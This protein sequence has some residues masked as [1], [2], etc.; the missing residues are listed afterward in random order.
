MPSACT[1]WC[2][3]WRRR[4]P[5]PKRGTSSADGRRWP[6]SPRSIRPR[7]HEASPGMAGARRLDALALALVGDAEVPRGAGENVSDL[8]NRLART[9]IPHSRTMGGG[10]PYERALAIREKVLWRT[11]TPVSQWDLTTSPHCIKGKDSM[12]RRRRSHRRA[13]VIVE[14]APGPEHLHV[15]MCL[16]NLAELY[17]AQGLYTQARPLFERAMAIVERGARPRGSLM[18]QRS[19][20]TLHFCIRRKGSTLRRSCS[21]KRH[22]P[23]ARKC[24]VPNIPTGGKSQNLARLYRAR[25]PR[26]ASGAVR[27]EGDGHPRESAGAEH[28]DVARDLKILAELIGHKGP[29][30][31][32]SHLTC[33][34]WPLRKGC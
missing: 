6:S 3:K 21:T 33:G 27:S 25:Y 17:R 9:S 19:S 7:V 15:A 32:L 30:D 12:C 1:G 31:R 16:N 22:W 8:L 34:R 24:S 26:C 29:M 5:P 28:P 4:G 13:L 10:T 23:F 20:T 18:W 2:G 11:S 14:K